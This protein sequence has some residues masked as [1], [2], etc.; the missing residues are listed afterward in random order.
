MA[1]LPDIIFKSLV[2]LRGAFRSVGRNKLRSFLS[3]LGVV[4]G[5]MAV[6]AIICIGQGARDEAVRQ[7][8]Q[9]GTRNIY[10][11]QMDLSSEQKAK[12]ARQHLEG[13]STWDMDRL[14]N[15]PAHI[16]QMASLKELSV[17]VMSSG[18]RISPQVIACSANYVEVLN[19]KIVAGRFIQQSDIDG[20]ELVCVLGSDVAAR[21]G[22]DGQL[23]EQLR[24]DNQTF[25]IVG[26]LDQMQQ[27]DSDSAA[28]S[29]RN[30]NEMIFLPMGANQWL[31]KAIYNIGRAPKMESEFSEIIIEISKSNHVI[32]TASI[33]QRIMEQSRK[34]ITDYQIVVPLELLH[35][36][37]KAHEMFNRFL[38][39]IAGISLLV[40]GIGIM[41][42]MLAT[43]SERKKEIGIRRAVGATKSHI[44]VQ[45]LIEST[46]LTLT[47]GVIGIFFGAVAAVAVAMAAP[48]HAAFSLTAVVLPLLMSIFVGLF[49]GL[50]PAYQA[51]RVD[52]IEALRYE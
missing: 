39:A 33:I 6:M 42:I 8:E 30:H 28:V 48:W 15:G 20:H 41:N 51:A 25:T 46:L 10:I 17:E 22:Q 13:L 43:I 40:G 52:P 29:V 2:F 21:L 36:S 44:I 37:H 16:R 32:T 23:Y 31:S 38:E 35:Q 24:M 50:Y 7:I 3:V 45:F 18:Q 34:G 14:K 27:S 49:F 9:L 47:G 19:L 26:L 4:F 1:P 11:K 5:V 12:A